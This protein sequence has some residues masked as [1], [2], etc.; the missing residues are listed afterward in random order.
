M[1][2]S[3]LALVLLESPATPDM[4]AIA[5]AIRARHPELPMAVEGGDAGARQNSPLIR[6]G[7]ELVAVMSMPAPVPEDSG[8]WSRASTTWPQADATDCER[9]R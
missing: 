1:S 2:I 7:N 6:C 8:L 3:F 4:V 9:G 5:K